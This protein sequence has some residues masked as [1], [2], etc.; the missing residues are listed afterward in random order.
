MVVVVVVAACVARAP[1]EDTGP[2]ADDEHPRDERQPG[3]EL[4]RDDDGREPERHETQ[5]EHARRVG[6]RDRGPERE[7][8]PRP[9]AGAD[10][11]AG[12][13]R[14]PVPGREGVRGTPERRHEQGEQDDPERRVVAPDEPR[15]PVARV[16]WRRR[17]VEQRRG[18]GR[19]PGD[20]T[21]RRRP[22]RERRAKEVARIRAQLVRAARR[23]DGRRDEA[24]PVAGTH[25][26]LPPAD[27]ARE[28]AIDEGE[29]GTAERR[30]VDGLEP[31]GRKAAGSRALR[32]AV[33]QGAGRPAR[34]RDR[35]SSSRAS[36]DG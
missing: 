3:I 20:E 2:D 11:V 33:R 26:D 17:P 36:S 31:Q 21:R 14:L 32:D 19:R 4:L 13:E 7:G 34:R 28:A 27:A 18:S 12:D 16:A 6:D 8:V 23:R 1:E 5:R 10:E 9:A 24:R 25:G 35:R 15:E 22:D 30:G 29:R